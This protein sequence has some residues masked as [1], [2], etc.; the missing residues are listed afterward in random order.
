MTRDTQPNARLDPIGFAAAILGRL[1][2]DGEPHARNDDHRYNLKWW[3]RGAWT[4]FSIHAVGTSFYFVD[5][6]TSEHV[7]IQIDTARLERRYR[8]SL[9]EIL[10]VVKSIEAPRTPSEAFLSVTG[11]IAALARHAMTCAGVTTDGAYLFATRPLDD[12]ERVQLY[13]MRNEDR[14]VE[15][16]VAGAPLK[17]IILDVPPRPFT[18]IGDPF[19]PTGYDHSRHILVSGERIEIPLDGIDHLDVMRALSSVPETARW[20]MPGWTDGNTGNRERNAA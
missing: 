17:A 19:S 12:S 15:E 6:D 10:E 3:G 14:I 2:A 13:V 5:T 20:E 9:T 4:A 11:R 7:C 1:I 8:R 18:K 16:I